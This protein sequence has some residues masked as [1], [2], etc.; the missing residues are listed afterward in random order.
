MFRTLYEAATGRHGER[1]FTAFL[2]GLVAALIAEVSLA[3]AISAA[4]FGACTVMLTAA[5]I[6]FNEPSHRFD[7]VDELARRRTQPPR[8]P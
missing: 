4:V 8:S 6:S 2:G 1:F 5:I 3:L 7:D